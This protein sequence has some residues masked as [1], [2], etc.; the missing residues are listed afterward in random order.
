VVD[1]SS[2]FS[3]NSEIKHGKYINCLDYAP[4]GNL[5]ATGDI[6]GA[7][8]IFDSKSKEV[9]GQ[10]FNNHGRGVRCVKFSP[11]SA[12]IVSGGEDLH[13]YLCDVESQ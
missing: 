10:V 13:I 2:D 9:K 8:R 4:S 7:V 12:S 3:L 11:D 1:I 5:M 6:D